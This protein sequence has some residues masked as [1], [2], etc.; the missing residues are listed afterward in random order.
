MSIDPRN[1]EHMNTRLVDT[2]STNAAARRRRSGIPA[3]AKPEGPAGPA[4]RPLRRRFLAAVTALLVL[5]GLVAAPSASAHAVVVSTNPADGSLLATA[6]SQVSIVFSEAVE[7]QL[8]ALRVFA[9]DGS[10][11]DVGSAGHPAGKA[12]T[13]SIGLRP[14]LKNGTYVVSWRVIS[15]DSHPVHGGFTF[16]IG[17]TSAPAAAGNAAAPAGD[18]TVGVLF[19]IARWLAFLGFALLVGPAFL[20]LAGAP[21]LL[22]QKRA[23]RVIAAGWFTLLL[24]TVAALLLQ[25]PYGAGFGLG[26]VFDGDVLQATMHTRLG[27]ALAWR[28]VLLGAAGVLVSWLAT[29]LAD[30]P[31]RSRLV[32]GGVGAVLAVAMAAT[33]ASVDHSGVGEQVA[34]ALPVDI[35]HLLAMAVWVGG[36]TALTVA[37]LWQPRKKAGDTASAETGPDDSGDSLSD[38]DALDAIRRFSPVAFTAVVVLAASGFY[39]G[40]R[41]VRT[42]DALTTTDYGRLL[43][44]KVSL[45]A[46]MVALGFLARRRLQA[47]KPDLPTLRRSVAAEF[48]IALVVLAVTS[49]LVESQPARETVNRV[50]SA[51][52]PFDTGAANGKGTVNI[53]LDPARVGIDALHVYILGPTGEQEAVPEVTAM[54]ALP[55]QEIGPLPVKLQNA[56]P[57]HYISPTATFPYAGDWQVIVVVRTTDI[58]ESTVILNVRV[59]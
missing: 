21:K 15:A 40:W 48:G 32:A 16:S 7:L 25:G 26:K 11:A 56:G 10:R 4:R 47:R 29:R 30:A 54:L 36:L 13:A 3:A 6:P 33:W 50:A 14:D 37:I 12:D 41:Q 53:T 28:L 20:A 46:V 9:P 2:S 23:R 17:T 52:Q 18:K 59:N 49:V 8:G 45:F 51:S 1:G 5:W 38:D 44:I 39:Q 42:W 34:L 35:T 43:L 27:T 55:A 31:R 19:G 22:R 24:G 58:D 57:G